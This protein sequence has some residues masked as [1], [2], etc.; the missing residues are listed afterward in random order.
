[1]SDSDSRLER[2]HDRRPRVVID[3]NVLVAA[4]LTPGKVASRA[5]RDLVGGGVQLL[6][7]ERIVEE[8]REV[9]ARPKF[10]RLS[11]DAVD[12]CIARLLE[13]AEMVRSVRQPMVL[14][15][16]DD[17]AFVEV[18]LCGDADAIVTGNAKH[19]PTQLGFDVVSPGRWLELRSVLGADE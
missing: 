9:L 19:F 3:T 8:Y 11:R 5:L 12:L 1:M 2:V 18:A 16:E 14:D 17:R 10:A 7:D 4:L 6:V 13:N 15:D